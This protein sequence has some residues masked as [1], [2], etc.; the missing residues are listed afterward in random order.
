MMSW[1]Q[2][3][4]E[5]LPEAVASAES[6]RAV[7]KIAAVAKVA[8]AKADKQA[9]QAE[10]K[11]AKA[12]AG[13]GGGK[14]ASTSRVHQLVAVNANERDEKVS[15]L[16]ARGPDGTKGFHTTESGGRWTGVEA[17]VV[18]HLN[19]TSMHTASAASSRFQLMPSE[20]TFTLL[21]VSPRLV[22]H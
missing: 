15:R 8:K 3:V 21:S 13:S 9:S 16:V 12:A 4:G 22:R 20:T 6:A 18:S 7:F 19:N 17:W 11:A 5:P 1:L 14:S 10:A 2:R